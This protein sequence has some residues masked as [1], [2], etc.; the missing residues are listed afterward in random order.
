[1]VYYSM[2]KQDWTI[3]FD[4]GSS[5]TYFNTNLLDAVNTAV[6]DWHPAKHPVAWVE[7]KLDVFS[8]PLD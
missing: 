2:N 3:I 4:D 1:M 8:L 7:T 5:A 6:A